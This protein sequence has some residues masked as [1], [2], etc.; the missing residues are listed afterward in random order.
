MEL[1]FYIESILGKTEDPFEVSTLGVADPPI[2][3][4]DNFLS[5]SFLLSSL[6]DIY[7]VEPL[8]GLRSP[9]VLSGPLIGDPR[10]STELYIPYA[11]FLL[12]TA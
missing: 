9:I 1:F 2:P 6:Y 11:P 8:T 12:V 5:I 7:I 3:G 4:I 10:K